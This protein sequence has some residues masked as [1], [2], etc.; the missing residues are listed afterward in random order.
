MSRHPIRLAV[1]IGLLI[2]SASSARP[3]ER[4]D[5]PQSARE[6]FQRGQDLL[7]KGRFRD[8][9]Q[10]FDAAVLQGMNDFPQVQLGRARS[11][12]GLKDYNA[13]IAR[14]TAFIG[15]FG[16]GGACRH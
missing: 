3:D 2:G 11:F 14:Y 10:A 12:I 13:A 6:E 9:L 5:F 15:E 1:V 7:K 16:A 4:T 8:A